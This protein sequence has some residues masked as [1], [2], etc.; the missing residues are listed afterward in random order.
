MRLIS[1]AF[2]FAVFASTAA[3]MIWLHIEPQLVFTAFAVVLAAGAWH[4]A[5][6][7][8]P[9]EKEDDE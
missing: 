7:Y 9:E 1:G 5:G 3:G 6:A 2:A 8:L 4:I